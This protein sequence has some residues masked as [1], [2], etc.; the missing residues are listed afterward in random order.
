MFLVLVLI[1]FMKT[2]LVVAAFQCFASM[3]EVSTPMLCSGGGGGGG[4]GSGGECG[5][6]LERIYHM[7]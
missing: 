3:A 4:G 2:R 6:A 1:E 5:G 7:S